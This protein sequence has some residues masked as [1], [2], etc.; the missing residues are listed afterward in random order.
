[1]S[2][3]RFVAGAVCA[4][5]LLSPSAASA[6]IVLITTGETITHVGDITPTPQM[7]PGT[8]NI[9]VGYKY[10]YYGLFWIDMWTSGGA[11]CVYEGKQYNPISEAEAAQ[12]L[13]KSE[14]ELSAPFLYRVP[15][16][17]L[18]LGP[19]LLLA[20]IGKVVSRGRSEPGPS[21]S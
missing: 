16:G 19:I 17:W 14:S 4:L 8:A 12:L 13:G 1:M 5:A 20:V 3:L 9:K 7:K 10:N 18:I 15:L 2:R 6:K 21:T 11:Y